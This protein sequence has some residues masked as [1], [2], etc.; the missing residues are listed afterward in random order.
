MCF[1]GFPDGSSGKESTCN[2]GDRGLIPGSRRSPGEGNGNPLQYCCLENPMD[3]GVWQA[4]VC[5]EGFLTFAPDVWWFWIYSILVWFGTFLAGVFCIDFFTGAFSSASFSLASLL[6]FCGTL[7]PLADILQSFTSSSSS[8]SASSKSCPLIST[9][10]EP[11]LGHR[12]HS[13][14]QGRISMARAAS[15]GPPLL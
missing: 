7:L 4:T 1:E 13:V 15:L 11:L 5:F 14:P 9:G 12:W 6:V 2:A 10:P 8:Y 3:R